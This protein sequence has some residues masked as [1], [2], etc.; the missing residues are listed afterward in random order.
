[1]IKQNTSG[2]YLPI[3]TIGCFFISAVNMAQLEA[4]KRGLIKN[5]LTVAEINR[6]WDQACAFRYLDENHNMQDSAAVAN[7]AAA[8]LNL[9]ARFREVATDT[10][11][12]P[13]WYAGAGEKRADYRIQKHKQN[14]P[15]KTHFVVVDRDGKLIEDPHEPPINNLGA[16]YTI[17]YR[18]DEWKN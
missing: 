10:G 6:I 3:Q 9:P 2:L 1:M 18:V 16:I 12:T 8:A 7:L 5:E 15:S 13:F 4:E 11:R 14:G 17:F